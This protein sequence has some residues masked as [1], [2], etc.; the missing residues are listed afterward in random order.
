LGTVHAYAE[1]FV[2]GWQARVS[3]A[4]LVKKVQQPLSLFKYGTEMLSRRP[5]KVILSEEISAG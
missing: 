1:R 5:Q 3:I 2:F 4:L